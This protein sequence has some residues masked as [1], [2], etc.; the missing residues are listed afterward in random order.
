[1]QPH[2]QGCVSFEEPNPVLPEA[3]AAAWQVHHGR[4]AGKRSAARRQR[5]QRRAAASVPMASMPPRHEGSG[6]EQSSVAE[7]VERR[8]GSA[9]QCSELIAQ[10]EV[11]RLS[12]IAAI[13]A[14]RGL[15]FSFSQDKHGCRVI[16]LALD[17]LPQAF[18]EELIR[19]LHGHVREAIASP[20]GNF[21]IQRVIQ[22]MPTVHAAF[23]AE[24]LV[25][26][27]AEVARHRFGCRIVARL[28][29]HS[30][31]DGN[32]IRFVDELL[33]DAA[34]LIRHSYGHFSIQSVLEHGLPQHRQSVAIALLAGVGAEETMACTALTRIGSNVIEAAMMHCSLDDASSLSEELL[35]YPGNVLQLAQ[36]Q[37][38]S[39]VL[40]ACLRRL[41]KHAVI[42]REVQAV[43]NELQSS[44]HGKKLLEI[45][46]SDELVGQD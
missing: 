38:G 27:A 36:N 10:L 43:S 17:V 44:K 22:V 45:V 3:T 30:A 23:V 4:R 29:E 14:L 33:I 42:W 25:G 9:R 37:Y 5:R 46:K 39:Y 18:K 40:R 6:E 24:E 32:T 1:M 20:H 11:D 16:Q 8:E 28:L 35:K 21:V 31:M 41:G 34:R 15:V 19:E 13:S 26:V 7:A 2:T 12:Q